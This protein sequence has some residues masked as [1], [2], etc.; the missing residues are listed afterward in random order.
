MTNGHPPTIIHNKLNF[1]GL[2]MCYLDYS[3]SS[4]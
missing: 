2:L 1:D 4:K 3:L